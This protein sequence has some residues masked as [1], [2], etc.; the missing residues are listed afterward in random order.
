MIRQLWL[1]ILNGLRFS[2]PF[3]VGGRRAY[4]AAVR[5]QI[6]GNQARIFGFFDQYP[7]V[8]PIRHEIDGLRRQ[9]QIEFDF[10][11]ARLEFRHMHVYV[12]P[13]ESDGS[14]DDQRSGRV[15]V[16][17]DFC[18]G[19]LDVAQDMDAALAPRVVRRSN[20]TPSRCSSRMSR[21]LIAATGTPR[22]RAAA[23][24][25]PLATTRANNEMSLI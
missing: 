7:D 4:D 20:W 8:A 15:R 24:R 18:L 22:S 5:G 6:T 14:R 9:P 13:A 2:M 17:A 3:E 1:Q 11:V 19:F 23:D 16:A 25:F 21:L 10:R 12:L